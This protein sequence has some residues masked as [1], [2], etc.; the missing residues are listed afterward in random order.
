M[1]DIELYNDSFQNYKGYQIPKAQLIL[2]DVPYN[3]GNNAYVSNP[4]WLR[5]AIT[6][7]ARVQT[8]LATKNINV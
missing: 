2:T 4:T 3:L 8:L 7:M 6:R 5:V 1:K